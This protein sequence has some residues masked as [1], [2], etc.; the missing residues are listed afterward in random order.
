MSIKKNSR[1]VF[2]SAGG[3]QR[4]MEDAVIYVT[5]RAEA[6]ALPTAGFVQG[7]VLFVIREAKMYMLDTDGGTWYNVA[8]GVSLG[9]EA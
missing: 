4:R 8:T 1:S 7:S 2:I 6:A 3:T 5:T 9:E